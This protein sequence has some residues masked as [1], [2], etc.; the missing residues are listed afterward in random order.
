MPSAERPARWLRRTEIRAA[1]AAG[2]AVAVL[3]GFQSLLFYGFVGMEYLEEAERQIQQRC[4]VL[5]RV[6]AARV[7]AP[8]DALDGMLEAITRGGPEPTVAVRLRGGDGRVART[9]G[10]WPASGRALL[11]RSQWERWRDVLRMAPESFLLRRIDGAG[12]ASYEVAL[13]LR[14]YRG[15]LDEVRD[16]LL[17]ILAVSFVAGVGIAL[18]AVRRSFAPLRAGTRVLASLDAGQLRARL[19]ERGTGDL[20]DQHA[21]ALN[22]ALDRIADA[23]E[24][25]RNFSADV[26]HEL[27]TPINRIRN[28]AEL[29]LMESADAKTAREAL[30][31]TLDSVEGLGR[32]VDALLLLARLDEHEQA[33]RPSRLSAD[34]W[35][36]GLLEL[37]R[38]LCSEQGIELTASVEPV[39]LRGD[40][41]L[42]D[43]AL[44]NLLD[45]AIVHGGKGGRIDVGVHA[46][47]GGVEVS[48]ADAGPGVPPRDRERIFDRFARLDPSRA[49]HGAGIGLALARAIAEAHGGTLGVTDSPLGGAR[50]ALWLPQGP[51]TA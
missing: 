9:W 12:G 15:E 4:E 32:L 24:R 6:G 42:L 17:V 36:G 25:L 11:A 50:F 33:L 20:V 39:V 2:T 16:G 49:G 13:S 23:Y 21:T 44:C 51:G 8:A 41:G 37:Y 3:L 34:E 47:D 35:L 5:E 40:P 28:A 18:L 26:A 43:R 1:L 31:T 10:A 45:N 29:G 7:D 27:R 14:H 30:Q 19:P 46:R 22:A 38:P 48:V